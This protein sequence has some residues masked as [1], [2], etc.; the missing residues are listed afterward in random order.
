[1]RLY[2]IGLNLFNRKPNK[3]IDFLLTHKF[4]DSKPQSIARF[5][6]NRKG[7][8]KQM[9]GVYLGDLQR[10]MNMEVLS[11]FVN[12]IDL[13]NLP[14]DEALRKFQAYFRLP[15]EAQKIERLM[16]AFSTSYYNSN[17]SGT[18]KNVDTIFL[19]S[20]AVV[21]LNTDLHN[22]NIK[23]EKKM[24]MED[25]VKNLRGIDNGKDVDPGY[26]SDIYRRISTC[27]LKPSND[28]VTQVSKVDA[29]IAGKKPLLV[30]P[31]R[32]LVCYCRLFEVFDPMLMRKDKD[33]GRHQRDVFL[34]NDLL[35]ITKL[36]NRKKNVLTYNFRESFPLLHMKIVLF[37]LPYCPNGM[38]LVNGCDGS[39]LVTF[40]AKDDGEL[41]KFVSDLNESILEVIS[42]FI[43]FF[44]SSFFLFIRSF[45]RSVIHTFV[46][47]FVCS[48][49]H[50]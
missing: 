45:V 47:S 19:L 34:F 11:H 46:R 2:R 5:L 50:S 26:L 30:Q 4:L 31:H 41:K 27:P 28:H 49:V 12:G 15:G 38:Q 13:H 21:M 1:K 3:G 20:Y 25:F 9:V 10:P 17:P 44:R 8:S 14:I 36:C 37:D 35:V 18:L 42:S 39:V 29:M 43:S 24:R 6:L 33:G 23:V 40:C 48:F 7:L 22:R 32:R 16:E